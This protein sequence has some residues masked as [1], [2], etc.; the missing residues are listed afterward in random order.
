[1]M[2]AT[3]LAGSA[4]GQTPQPQTTKVRVE[5]GV[6]AGSVESGANVFKAIPF[7]VAPVGALRWKPPQQPAAWR[8]E[9]A[10]TQFALP[11]SQPVEGDKPNGG[12]VSGA[13]GE[14][15]LYLNVWAP[16]N[17]KGAPVMLWLYGGAGFLGGAHLG[18]YNG[19]SF[20]R[21]GVILVTANYRLGAL[22]NFAHPALDKAAAPGEPLGSYALMD[23]VAALQWVQRN[24]AAFGGDPKNVTLFGQSAGGAMVTNLLS[25]PS[26]KGLFAKA[27]VH[28]GA[29]L[30]PAPTLAEAEAAG[31]KIG[32]ALGVPAAEATPE[33]LRA[34]PASAFIA[35]KDT[36]RGTGAPIDGRFRTTSTIDA[37]KAHK[38]IDVPLIVGSNSGEPGA[39][40]AKELASLASGGAPSFLYRFSYV[41]A[42]R[43]AE[44]PNGAPH[45]AE[46][47]Y[48]FAS[49]ST[50]ATGGGSH[51]TDHDR[52]V[53]E[54]MHSCWVAFAKAKSVGGGIRCANNFTWPAYTQAGDKAAV[55]GETPSVATAASLPKFAPR[56]PAASH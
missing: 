12:G 35:N 49:L 22:G 31:V 10:A 13:S 27:I 2:A 38:E 44:Q 24:I 33:R 5:S 48:A 36:Q 25:I 40:S 21:D 8:S 32:D 42:W 14:D 53:A 45:S 17:A 3:A 56:A 29:N 6:L 28:S 16:P 20:A 34:L 41:P 43:T 50:A 15:C 7:A 55:F 39:D 4:L 51:V 47:P 30:R 37:L 46:I 1:M 9:R 54:Q 52:Q 19:S 11:C 23:A 26:A 18:A